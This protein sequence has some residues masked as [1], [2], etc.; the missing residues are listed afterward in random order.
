MFLI[1]VSILLKKV[2]T[3]SFFPEG[4]TSYSYHINY[5]IL[6]VTNN[7]DLSGRGNPQPLKTSNLDCFVTYGFSQ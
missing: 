3:L 5:A 6:I 2:N 7:P 1:R 4:N